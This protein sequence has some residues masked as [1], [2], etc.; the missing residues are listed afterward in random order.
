MDF[1]AR[2][3]IAALV[4]IVT[5]LP[6]RAAAEC[7][8]KA[9]D[10]PKGNK[11]YLYFPQADDEEF[12]DEFYLIPL[13]KF[14]RIDGVSPLKQFSKDLL[15]P[16]LGGTTAVL[17]DAVHA[18]VVD[19][20]CEFSVEVAQTT[21]APNPDEARWQVVGIGS[22]GHD[23]HYGQAQLVDGEDATPKDYARVW[24][25]RFRDECMTSSASGELGALE[26]TNSTLA[27]WA[28]AIGHT[29]S[30]EA[31][32]GYGLRHDYSEPRQEQSTTSEF[33]NPDATEDP[34]ENHILISQ[35]SSDAWK[36]CQIR[37][38]KA[39][40]FSDT[41]YEVLGHNIGLN[42]K[43]VHNWD[44]TNINERA[45][46]SMTVTILSMAD[47]L[48]MS[49][50]YTGARGPWGKPTITK[51]NVGDS[52][53]IEFQGDD[54]NA[55]EVKLAEPKEWN[56]DPGMVGE[57]ND[58]GIVAEGEVFHIGVTFEQDDPIFVHGT[59]L[60]GSDAQPL[61]LRPRMIGYD[62][63]P[64][65]P[66][67]G[68]VM[69]NFYG[70]SGSSSGGPPPGPGPVS[71]EL[72]IRDLQ[73]FFLP[74]LADINTMVDGLP[75]AD[76]RGLPVFQRP[77]ARRRQLPSSFVVGDEPVSFEIAA[78]TD[79]RHVDITHDPKDCKPEDVSDGVDRSDAPDC[80]EG[81]SLSL[82]PSTYIYVT[83]TVVE[84][85]A[86]HF[87]AASGRM[88]TGPLESK[89]FFQVAGIIPDLNNNGVDDLLDIRSGTSTDDNN[90]G[91]PDDAECSI[92]VRW[93]VIIVA[94]I[95]VL[96]WWRR[97]RSRN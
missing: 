82:F 7:Y 81:T 57:N 39:R 34:Q 12:T 93:I 56:E 77:I 63:G 47:D 80:N 79:P 83:A 43:T 74:R 26:G 10:S 54:Y 67:T 23:S 31:G 96:W 60:Y 52:D 70:D 58:P 61:P 95:L 87:D 11:L 40:H 65:E 33:V 38:D 91:V 85:N 15:D 66:D 13:L 22:D 53:K 94:F 35:T 29:A 50:H 24:A 1:T 2:T 76:I 8:W 25:G 9:Y 64:P 84:P 4:A 17:R 69:L 45:A 72:E 48:T 73:V 16:N 88:V 49:W 75:L 55:F 41:S 44:F 21:D 28:R 90:N 19:D 18:V 97:R 32:H 59:L 86:R 30:H 14:G 68:S 3:C 92:P 71:N 78:M 5:I 42:I 46:H 51:I 36:R 27:R 89:L 62:V 6:Q 20:Y 37:A